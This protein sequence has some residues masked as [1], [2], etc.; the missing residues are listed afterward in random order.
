M[1]QSNTHGDN[2]RKAVF[3]TTL[4]VMIA[5]IGCITFVIILAGLFGGMWLDGY[6]NTKPILTLILLVISIPVSLAVMLIIARSAAKKI[7]TR[8]K[9]SDIPEKEVKEI[10]S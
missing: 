7:V 4:L 2:A 3:N 1:S 10:G 5:Q 9:S 8:V 6:F